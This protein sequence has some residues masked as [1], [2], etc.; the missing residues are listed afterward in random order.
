ML[1]KKF[2]VV[3]SQGL[4][5]GFESENCVAVTLLSMS[6]SIFALISRALRVIVSVKT[7]WPRLIFWV[8]VKAYW[9]PSSFSLSIGL[10]KT[11]RLSLFVGRLFGSMLALCKRFVFIF[12]VVRASVGDIPLPLNRLLTCWRALLSC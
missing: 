3:C 8:F 6:A 9:A 2:G 4:W 7:F 10:L 11:M 12:P 5:D 1:V